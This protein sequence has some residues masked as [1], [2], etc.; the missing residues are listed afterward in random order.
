M[1]RSDLFRPWVLFTYGGMWLDLR[2]TRPLRGGSR[3]SSQRRSAGIPGSQCR[4]KSD[5]YLW[6][7]PKPGTQHLQMTP[8]ASSHRSS[9]VLSE[10]MS[11]KKL[12]GGRCCVFPEEFSNF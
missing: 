10:R 8:A 5:V 7:S 11:S 12:A 2:G 3:R 6:V 9:V 4:I 1:A